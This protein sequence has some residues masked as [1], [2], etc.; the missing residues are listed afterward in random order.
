MLDKNHPQGLNAPLPL[1]I[2]HHLI[3]ACLRENP[4]EVE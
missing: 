1:A 3:R 4:G 2:A